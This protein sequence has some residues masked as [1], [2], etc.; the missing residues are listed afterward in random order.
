M[1]KKEKV[2]FVG[3]R[4][5]VLL[6]ANT[7]LRLAT[8][9]EATSGW[10]DQAEKVFENFDKQDEKTYTDISGEQEPDEGEKPP[11]ASPLRRVRTL[12]VKKNT[13]KERSKRPPPKEAEKKP[14]A[15]TPQEEPTVSQ[16]PEKEQGE[17][18]R[19]ETP[20]P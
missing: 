7:Q 11:E 17:E 2:A 8:A 15:N 10:A 9:E 19:P 16:D 14:L 13:L 5:Q 20:G 4:G 3:W 18:G 12:V 1:P 6:V